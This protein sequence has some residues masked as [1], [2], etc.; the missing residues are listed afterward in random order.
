[1][2]SRERPTSQRDEPLKELCA[3]YMAPPIVSHV[4]SGGATVIARGP[5][6]KV[7]TGVLALKRFPSQ[8]VDRSHLLPVRRNFRRNLAL[9]IPAI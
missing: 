5:R 6:T 1:M 8:S 2:H 9:L 4:P 7:C 3:M